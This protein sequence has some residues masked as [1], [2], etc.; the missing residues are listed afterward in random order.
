MTAIRERMLRPNTGLLQFW[1]SPIV[2][3]SLATGAVAAV[4][5]G[6]A[7]TAMHDASVLRR[8]VHQLAAQV[9]AEESALAFVQSDGQAVRRAVNAVGITGADSVFLLVAA[10][11]FVNDLFVGC[12]LGVVYAVVTTVRTAT[13]CNRVLAEPIAAQ[14]DR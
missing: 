5:L 13:L 8:E 12:V 14:G 3:C 6:R 7:V 11:A 2:L 1:R 9:A 4:V 10:S